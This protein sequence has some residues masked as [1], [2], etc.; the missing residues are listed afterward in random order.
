MKR[1]ARAGPVVYDLFEPAGPARAAAIFLHGFG[2][3]RD[4]EK[5]RFFAEALPAR[6]CA[7]L[8]PDLQGHGES[9]G[10]IGDLTIGGAIGDLLRVAEDP[11]FRN[12]P[13]RYLIGSSLG[14]LVGMWA[15]VDR[16]G[17]FH[18]LALLAPALGF[19][20]R[21][22]AAAPPGSIEAW[23]RGEPFRL[24]N[25]WLDVALSNRLLLEGPS[26]TTEELIRRFETPALLLHGGC[27]DSVP[28]EE[29]W[30]FFR[31]SRAPL[32]ML[33]ISEGDHRLTAHK[34]TLAAEAARF[35]G[36]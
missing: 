3:R 6:G 7:V 34:E 13:R 1:T 36:L 2:S 23:R 5:S 10:A 12:A 22:V 28:V 35:F 27:D 17:L 16:P 18:R 11:L 21:L 20:E 24:R 31:K 26:R 29:S 30:S 32:E 14:A 19:L 8:A 4:G 9:G 15:S 25:H 33:L